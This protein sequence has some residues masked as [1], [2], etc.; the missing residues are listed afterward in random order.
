MLIQAAS[1]A[2][3]LQREIGERY[4]LSQPAVSKILR[5]SISGPNDPGGRFEGDNI[6]EPNNSPG[7][8]VPLFSSLG[9]FPKSPS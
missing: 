6:T 5:R 3:M 1:E 4:G 8:S 2:G 7:A 9:S